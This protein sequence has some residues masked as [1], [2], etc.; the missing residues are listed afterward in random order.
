MDKRF[1]LALLLTMGVIVITPRLFPGA[2]RQAVTPAASTATPTQAAGTPAPDVAPQ[3]A[4]SGA[5]VTTPD[6]APA[7]PIVPAVEVRTV[8]LANALAT[9]DFSTRGAALL[10]ADLPRYER[11]GGGTGVVRLSDGDVPLVRYRLIAGGDTIAL[12][13]MDFAVVEDSLNGRARLTFTAPLGAGSARIAYTLA[14]SNYLADV[15]VQV[16]GV[17]APAFLL[18]DLPQGFDTQERDSVDDRRHLAYAM[19]T[20]AGG[21]DRVDFRS[22]DPGERLLRPGPFT[23]TVA[24]SKYFLVGLL[25]RD[26]AASPLA[27]LQV[28]G[29]MR[30]N[31]V[32]ARAQATV[33]SP[34]GPD[35]VALE[36]YAGPQEWERLVALGREFEHVNPYGGWISGV[37]QPFATIV[38]RILLWMKR[39]L[40]LEYGWIL[41][42][43][44]VAIRVLMWPLNSK[45]MRSQMTMQ[46]IAPAV[47]AAQNKHKGD[48]EKQ[49]A[50]VMK[51]YADAG[52]SPFAP[53]AGCLP[54]LLPMPI[55]LALFFVFQ[56]TI[57]FRGVPFLW[58]PDISVADPY[59]IAPFITGG[60]MF[61]LSWIG[62]RNSP[63]NP[64]TKMMAY[65]MPVMMTVFGINFA[66][67]LNLYW[68]VQ[69]FAALPQQWLIS[70][71]RGKT[72]AAAVVVDGG[73]RKR[74]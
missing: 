60:S 46:R 2:A 44:G 52:I 20:P 47:Q 26:S 49:R 37:V 7:A 57:E 29:A 41:V 48:S 16:R 5:A 13:A 69:N 38:M 19:R 64:Q 68:F 50:E 24:K 71:E 73:E 61:L 30:I 17:S 28:T 43:F 45:M 10:G 18:T 12:D 55:L 40:V 72:Q 15:D 9:Y 59:Y 39:T 36:L 25:A 66:A 22:P 51:V 3:A 11:L 31:K 33:I 65:L 63:P 53:L 21:A 70:N 56:N 62:M 23:W 27:E 42:I 34:I 6:A 67:G 14:D 58:F 4:P 35:G 54:M 8:R 74:R 1:F 32:A